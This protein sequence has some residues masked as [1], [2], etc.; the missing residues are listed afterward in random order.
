MG[1]VALHLAPHTDAERLS[2]LESA[3]RSSKNKQRVVQEAQKAVANSTDSPLR[4]LP[5][6]THP[7]ALV[8][9]GP[10]ASAYHAPRYQ[11]PATQHDA[12]AAAGVLREVQRVRDVSPAQ[13]VLAAQHQPQQQRSQGVPVTFQDMH[14][15]K[16]VAD[17][18]RRYSQATTEALRPAVGQPL[19]PVQ[20]DDEDTHGAS[21]MRRSDY[22]SEC[23]IPDTSQADADSVSR[24]RAVEQNRHWGSL[25]SGHLLPSAQ[26]SSS[27]LRASVVA[28]ATAPPK[29]STADRQ[30]LS[31][32]N[33][34]AS[35]FVSQFAGDASQ[36]SPTRNATWSTRWLTKSRE[37]HSD[38]QIVDEDSCRRYQAAEQLDAPLRVLDANAPSVT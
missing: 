13:A 1:P 37:F 11:R 21:S 28:A 23:G 22:S 8:S 19:S 17:E 36:A 9:R 32:F 6:L 2:P 12:V 30:G 14:A 10:L 25:L 5:S 31:L 27:A 3:R 34:E 15:A 18:P 7:S 35:V 16:H 20:S 29:Q 38:D 24:D 4:S 33:P 26:T